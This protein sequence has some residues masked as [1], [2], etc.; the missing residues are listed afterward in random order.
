MTD[1]DLA[2]IVRRTIRNQQDFRTALGQRFADAEIVP[3][4]LANRYA[5]ADAAKIDRPRDGPFVKN[6]LLVELA[7][8]R[9]IDLVPDEDD[10]T[11]IEHGHGI[12]AAGVVLPWDTDD[13]AWPAIGG[14]GGETFNGFPA[15]AD[16]G[17]LQHQILRRIAGNEQF[18]QHQELRAFA[19]RLGPRLAR[20]GQ[21]AGN[22]ADRRIELRDGDT[23]G[24][25]DRALLCHAIHLAMAFFFRNRLRS[26]AGIKDRTTRIGGIFTRKT[27]RSALRFIQ[28]S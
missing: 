14:I 3:D 28:N 15:S 21:I 23:D 8:V 13:D 6:P 12:V 20:L 27:T 10:F 1:I 7:V 9:Q 24:L 19:R 18:S 11:A 2:T 17:R 16:E 25:S 5:K 26:P 4:L 22:V